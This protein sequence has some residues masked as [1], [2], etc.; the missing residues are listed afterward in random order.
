[1]PVFRH[2]EEDDKAEKALACYTPHGTRDEHCG[3]CRYFHAPGTCDRVRGAVVAGGWC[4]F[5]K[6][7]AAYAKH[8]RW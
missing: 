8:R 2:A 3:I 5:W 4:K 1:M 7:K 6:V